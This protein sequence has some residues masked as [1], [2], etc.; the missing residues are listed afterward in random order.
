MGF[1]REAADSAVER[2]GRG[3]TEAATSAVGAAVDMTDVTRSDVTGYDG[4][5]AGGGGGLV[6]CFSKLEDGVWCP[7][8]DVDGSVVGFGDRQ[9]LHGG[10]G[11]VV[12]VDEVSELG[13]VFMN[14]GRV[15][16]LEGAAKNAGDPGVRGVGWHPGPVY[17]VVPEDADPD[18]ALATKGCAKVLLVELGGCVDAARC[19][20]RVF[21]DRPRQEG[22]TAPGAGRVE[23]SVRVRAVPWT[24]L[25]GAVVWALVP[26]FAVDDHA[27]R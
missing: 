18:V 25:N 13:A 17:V 26:A 22:C 23:R 6:E 12:H 7:G 9:C 15:A 5:W 2:D 10:R 1:A 20:G 19:R 4:G 21:G 8:C 3:E 24:G 16:A 27:A 14:A 11:D